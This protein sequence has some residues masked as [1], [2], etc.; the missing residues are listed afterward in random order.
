METLDEYY[1]KFVFK[2]ENPNTKYIFDIP[3]S[4]FE[5]DDELFKKI[6]TNMKTLK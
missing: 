2:I 6:T 5:V 3:K 1:E 4:T